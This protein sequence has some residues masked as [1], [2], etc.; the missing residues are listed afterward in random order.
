M[1]SIAPKKAIYRLPPDVRR[2]PLQVGKIIYLT[3][4]TAIILVLFHMAFGHL[5]LLRGKAF[6]YAPS[7]TVALEFDARIVRVRAG[8]G[9]RVAPGELLLTYDSLAVRR[10]LV[11]FATR[12]SELEERLGQA[13]I[14]RARLEATIAAARSY[15]M[16]TSEV[17]EAVSGLLGRGLAANSR[18]STEAHRNFEARRDLLAFIAERDQLEKEIARLGESLRTTRGYLADLVGRFNS[19]EVR[20][21]DGGIVANLA[22]LPGAVVGKGQELLRVFSGAPF[23]LAYMEDSSYIPYRPGDPVL[24]KFPGASTRLGRVAKRMWV[25]DRLPEEFQPQFKPTD[26]EY[27]VYIELDPEILTQFPVM[28]TATVYK[29]LGLEAALAVTQQIKQGTARLRAW[30][31]GLWPAP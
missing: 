14:E 5:Y 26:R 3:A 12:I 24:V 1:K 21:V 4:I 19:G 2:E 13:R 23:V 16:L 17:E 7:R 27:L 11:E 30:A 8:E 10:D 22:V 28:T 20:T 31:S 29:P 6:V 15:S 25:A 9:E 18:L